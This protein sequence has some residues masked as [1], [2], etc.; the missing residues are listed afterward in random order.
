MVGRSGHGGGDRRS[1]KARKHDSEG[2]AAHHSDPPT[3][4][5][6]KHRK[7]PLRAIYDT[8]TKAA[9]QG[10]VA[11]MR[12]RGLEVHESDVFDFNGISRR[13]GWRMLE[14]FENGELKHGPRRIENDPERIGMRG[15]PRVITSEYLEKI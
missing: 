4:E 9:V 8:P 7:L 12:S 2:F 5:T 6:P 13:S 3:P 15:R 11:Y 14:I 10:T 1:E